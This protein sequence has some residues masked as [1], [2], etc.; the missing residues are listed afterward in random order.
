MKSKYESVELSIVIPVLN[1]E[2]CIPDLVSEINAEMKS[3]SIPRRTEVIFVDD[4]STDAT[5]M[6]IEGARRK[7]PALNIRVMRHNRTF[8][9]THAL[10]LGFQQ[11]RGE[12]VVALDGDGQNDPADISMLIE[13]QRVSGVDCV[14]GW[15]SERKG[16]RGLRIGF[17]KIANAMLMKASGVAIHDS[18]CTLKAYRGEVIRSV[19]LF[20]DM[21]RIIPFQIVALG[22]TTAEIP[23]THRQR[24]AGTSKYSLGRTFRVL[25]DIIVAYFVKRFMLRPMHL[26]GSLGSFVILIGAVGFFFAVGLKLFGIFDFVETPALLISLV[27]GIGGL[28]IMGIGLIAEMLNRR[29][30]AGN[31]SAHPF[32]WAEH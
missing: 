26:L 20:G 7:Y 32:G 9:Q 2:Q 3:G 27:L 4:G 25:Q 23:V 31:A 24:T 22:G 6:E 30:G 14:S 12:I 13:K 8:G 16:D 28:N 15:R 19:P 10:A 18:G 29:T 1:E 21:H 5:L 17:S 11:S